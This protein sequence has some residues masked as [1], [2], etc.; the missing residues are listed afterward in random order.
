MI[1]YKRNFDENRRIYFLIKEE[2]VF[3]KYIT[4]LDKVSNIIK[5][6]FN[7]QLIYSKK[8]INAKK[9]W[10]KL[11]FQ[12]FYAPIIFDENYYPKVLLEKF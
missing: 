6:K 3:I 1:I 12:Y 7:S 11:D 4:I 8:C 10:L 5:I 2:K 9:T